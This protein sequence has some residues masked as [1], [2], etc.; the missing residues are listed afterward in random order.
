MLWKRRSLR[1]SG[2]EVRVL[3]PFDLFSCQMHALCRSW[4]WKKWLVAWPQ[5]PTF[6]WIPLW[7]LHRVVERWLNCWWY[8]W[9]DLSDVVNCYVDWW[10]LFNVVWLSCC[11]SSDLLWAFMNI[12]VYVL[13]KYHACGMFIGSRESI[14]VAVSVVKPEW[15]RVGINVVVSWRVWVISRFAWGAWSPLLTVA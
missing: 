3:Y 14:V 15:Y 11:E 7:Q 13:L 1:T 10:D 8:C 2:F 6:V 5:P 4:V 9:W 12:I